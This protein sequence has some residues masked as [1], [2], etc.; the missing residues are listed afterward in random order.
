MELG[1]AL[2]HYATILATVAL[3]VA[4]FLTLRKGPSKEGVLRLSA[5]DLFYGL[6]AILVVVSGLL[7]VFLGDVPAGEWGGNSLFWTKMALFGVVGILSVFPTLRFLA[8][9]KA[10]NADGTL[11][12]DRTWRLTKPFVHSQFALFLIIPIFAVLMGN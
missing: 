9:K 7:R 6:G 4:E 11:P 5:L 3:L 2:F 8:W 12:D 10:L 1:L